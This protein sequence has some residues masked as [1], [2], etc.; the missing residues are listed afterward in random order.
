MNYIKNECNKYFPNGL[1]GFI[2]SDDDDESYAQMLYL[3]KL[4]N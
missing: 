2:S 3:Q 4:M 1:I